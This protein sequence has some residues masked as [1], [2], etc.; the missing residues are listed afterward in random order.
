MS[1]ECKV[2]HA[3]ACKACCLICP[4]DTT[5]DSA[6]NRT[7]LSYVH[8]KGDMRTVLEFRDISWCLKSLGLICQ[9]GYLA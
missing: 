6:K 3:K 8:R 7:G 5:A 2:S 4:R 9:T 1:S